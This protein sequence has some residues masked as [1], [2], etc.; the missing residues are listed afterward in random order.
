MGTGRGRSMSA[1][2]PRDLCVHACAW[3]SKC[4]ERCRHRVLA[5]A[6]KWGQ[7]RETQLSHVQQYKFTAFKCSRSCVSEVSQRSCATSTGLAR[8]LPRRLYC[9]DML[10]TSKHDTQKPQGMVYVTT[11]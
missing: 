9:C 6:T 5:T 11:R 3:H 7:M 8:R 1:F 4:C 10:S 2:V